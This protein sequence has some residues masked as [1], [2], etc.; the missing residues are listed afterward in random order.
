LSSIV[1]EVLEFL[2][3]VVFVELHV[4]HALSEFFKHQ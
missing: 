1:E 2:F 3:L 4:I